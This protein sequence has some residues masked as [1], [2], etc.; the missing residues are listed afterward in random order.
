MA[1][2]GKP[3]KGRIGQV[4][5]RSQ[6]EHPNGHWIKRDSKTG[7]IMDVKQDQNPF[8]GVRKEK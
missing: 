7:Q 4:T 8:K 3:G 6:F 5:D 1:K 2:N